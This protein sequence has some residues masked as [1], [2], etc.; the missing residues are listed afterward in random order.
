[1]LGLDTFRGR[2]RQRV[3]RIVPLQN[4]HIQ[5]FDNM[6]GRFTKQA[7][8]MTES[9]SSTSNTAP[10][11]STRRRR[12]LS[13]SNKST[14]AGRCRGAVIDGI[15]ILRRDQA[16]ILEQT[17]QLMFACEVLLFVEYME[18]MMPVMYAICL[19]GEWILPNAK[20]NLIVRH[21][22]STEVD[23][24]IGTTFMYA[25]L[26]L[27]SMLAMYWVMKVRYGISAFYQLAFLLETYW[28][29]LQG[30]LVGSFIVV[31]LAA[32]EHQGT[33]FSFQ[34][35]HCQEHQVST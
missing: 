23:N 15:Y 35:N 5:R 21:M 1:M 24:N 25:S 11:P 16:R 13:Q 4:E 8:G 28:M 31:I 14:A 3:Q 20:Y 17:L 33:D 30:K 7:D 19:G 22:S 18:V 27:V 2:N 6:D 29:T 9:L 12:Y 32:T 10:A 34:F 26:E